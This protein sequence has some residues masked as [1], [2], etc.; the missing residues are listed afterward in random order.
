[1]RRITGIGAGHC[2]S[3]GMRPGGWTR[4][5]AA[6]V[7]LGPGQWHTRRRQLSGRSFDSVTLFAAP[8][9]EP[10]AKGPG[11][12]DTITAWARTLIYKIKSPSQIPIQVHHG[13]FSVAEQ[14]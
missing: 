10:E 12:L 6:E 13:R 11:G 2:A 1:M 3:A 4:A 14:Q 9:N 7:T 5:P 8:C